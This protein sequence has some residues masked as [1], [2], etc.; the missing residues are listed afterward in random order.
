MWHKK[1]SRYKTNL[2]EDQYYSISNKLRKEKKITDE[3]EI[4]LSSLTLEDIIGLKIELV[5]KSVNHNLFGLQI[6]E[7]VNNIVKDAV[8]RY[9]FSSTRNMTEGSRLLGI[10]K[11][12]YT[13]LLDKFKI[14][15]YFNKSNIREEA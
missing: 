2:K 8:L 4:L 11:V 3:F 15:E 9:S 5:S 13:Q 14:K 10:H 6:W 1:R 12:N 7:E